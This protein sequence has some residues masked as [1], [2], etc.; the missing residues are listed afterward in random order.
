MSPEN[1]VGEA[2]VTRLPDMNANKRDPKSILRNTQTSTRVPT[3]L[4]FQLC[5]NP[6]HTPPPL[7]PYTNQKA[8]QLGPMATVLFLVCPISAGHGVPRC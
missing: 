4:P 2:F 5:P 3:A 7:P 8:E 1:G 6:L